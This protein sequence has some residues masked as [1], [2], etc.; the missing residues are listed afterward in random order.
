MK[1]KKEETRVGW[2]FRAWIFQNAKWRAEHVNLVGKHEQRK[3]EKDFVV[4]WSLFKL[5]TV[6]CVFSEMVIIF[7]S[8][9][10]CVDVFETCGY[11]DKVVRWMDKSK[12]NA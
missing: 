8:S 7:C 11:Q 12:K 9:C 10:V 2:G 1:Q 3:K 5:Q 6:L 4:R